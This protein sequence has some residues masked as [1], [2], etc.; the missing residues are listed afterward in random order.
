MFYEALLYY[1]CWFH[2]P[3]DI[4]SSAEH[5]STH[6]AIFSSVLFLL[7]LK[8]CSQIPLALFS[9]E[10]RDQVSHPYKSVVYVSS[11]YSYSK[12]EHRTLWTKF[13]E[14]NLLLNSACMQFWFSSAVILSCQPS[15][16][17]T[18]TS[19]GGGD[20]WG[21][22]MQSSQRGGKMGSKMNSENKKNRFSVLKKF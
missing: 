10:A 16:H 5:T 6:H 20:R 7:P 13:P 18:C 14:F 21:Y 1:H 12:L 15:V 22:P 2:H 4:W 3:I 19:T 17:E 8:P 11:S 9:R